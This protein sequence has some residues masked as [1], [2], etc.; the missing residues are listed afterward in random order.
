[1]QFK[2]ES[3]F[4]N[5]LNLLSVKGLIPFLQKK[6]IHWDWFPKAAYEME[7]HLSVADSKAKP[8]WD[9]ATELLE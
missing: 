1:M 9:T 2:G 8:C 4:M 6:V 7:P 5:V 3:T